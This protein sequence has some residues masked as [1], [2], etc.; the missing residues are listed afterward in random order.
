MRLPCVFV[1]VQTGET[2][3]CIYSKVLAFAFT[4]HTGPVELREVQC[5]SHE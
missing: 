1:R 3:L 4:G 5:Q 2:M